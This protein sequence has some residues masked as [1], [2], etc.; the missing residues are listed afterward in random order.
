[1]AAHNKGEIQYQEE[2]GF[3]SGGKTPNN[4]A[5]IEEK[6]KSVGAAKETSNKPIDPKENTPSGQTMIG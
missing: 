3:G 6:S 2:R 1:M 5:L 4:D